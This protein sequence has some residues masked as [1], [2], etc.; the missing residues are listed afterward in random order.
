MFAFT[1]GPHGQYRLSIF[2]KIKERVLG[3]GED[4]SEFLI[5]MGFSDFRL[6]EETRW[7]ALSC[8][9]KKRSID[10]DGAW[11]EKERE[12]KEVFVGKKMNH[13]P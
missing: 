6:S 11:R 2:E 5:C 4:S 7:C 3:V 8:V 1:P 12:K 9:A 13:G 10:G